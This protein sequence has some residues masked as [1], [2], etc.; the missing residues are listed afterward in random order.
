CKETL[1]A[2]GTNESKTPFVR[3]AD[4]A[5]LNPLVLQALSGQKVIDD[6][7]VVAILHN[8][9]RE[10]MYEHGFRRYVGDIWDGRE[11]RTDLVRGQEEANWVHGSP[12]MSIV[13][14]D[15]FQ[16][17]GKVEFLTWQT[18]HFTRALAGV[19]AD[20]RTPEAYIVDKHSRQWTSDA[21]V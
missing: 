1:A 16:R 17:T 11:F 18:Y 12:M 4:L 8:L 6:E 3:T 15:L 21:N 5:Q 9:E 20:W 7:T 19:N 10:L 14:G 13:L 2:L